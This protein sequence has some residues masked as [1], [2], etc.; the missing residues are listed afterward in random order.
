VVSSLFELDLEQEK[1]EKTKSIR[2]YKADLIM[3]LFFINND[4]IMKEFKKYGSVKY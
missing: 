3:L 2:I 4:T 1:K